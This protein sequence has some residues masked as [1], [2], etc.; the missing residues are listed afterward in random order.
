MTPENFFYYEQ[1]ANELS[2]NE[3]SY[4]EE[5][6]LCKFDR[7]IGF[8]AKI[9]CNKSIQTLS[10]KQSSMFKENENDYL[11]SKILSKKSSTTK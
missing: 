6:L 8:P 5:S 3:G 1:I 2:R 10:N 7:E 9:E 4:L 11:L